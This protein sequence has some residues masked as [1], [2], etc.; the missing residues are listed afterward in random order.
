MPRLT[1]RAK[2][3]ASLVVLFVLF[4]GGQIWINIS[5][6]RQGMEDEIRQSSRVIADTL[7][8]GVTYPMARGEMGE[9]RLQLKEFKKKVKDMELCIFD[10]EQVV[11]MATETNQEGTV[12]SKTIALPELAAAISQLLRDGR[13][14]ADVYKETVG[15]TLYMTRLEVIKNGPQC[16]HCHGE[17]HAVLGGILI[18]QDRGAVERSLARLRN[19][20]L[21][22]GVL[23]CL[24]VCA[25]VLFLITRLV[26]NP[27]RRVA[28]SVSQSVEQ[29]I[30]SSSQVTESSQALADG[31]SVQAS[32]LEETS[33]SMEE[34]ASMTHQNSEHAGQAN[35][36]ARE[37]SGLAVAGVTAVEQM[38]TAIDKI[39]RSAA[40]TAKILKSIDEIAFQTNLLALNAA[41]EAARA[42]EAGK[43]FAV[44]AEEVRNLARRSAEA[45]RSTAELIE[46]SQKNADEGVAVTAEVAGTLGNIKENAGKV[47][48]LIS[49][50]ATASKE[51]TQGVDQINKAVAEMD[52][53][54]QQNA[55]GA[56]ESAAAAKELLA[57]A[58]TLKVRVDELMAII[59]GSKPMS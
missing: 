45:A 6:Q 39:K 15:D 9:V 49:E 32:S 48:A 17:S 47:A 53:V 27:V 35:T 55:A 18:R 20:N 43:G 21:V 26:I 29:M 8:N 57:E 14:P 11:A 37:A 42:G 33:A 1:L 13:S 10:F 38:T 59:T 34:M 19:L 44:V 12:L 3:T 31:S 51:Q 30:S 56:E 54:V 52:K 4:I 16:F 7:L 46:G 58:E 28:E 22:T 24:A 50:I 36:A 23:G 2:V 41:V 40:E 25:A 5:G